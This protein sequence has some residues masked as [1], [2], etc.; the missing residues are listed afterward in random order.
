[1]MVLGQKCYRGPFRGNVQCV[2]MF[3]YRFRSVRPFWSNYI[4]VKVLV[5]ELRQMGL[6]SRSGVLLGASGRGQQV[7]SRFRGPV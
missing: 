6:P 1:M 7:R 5:S 4:L 3:Y 2:H